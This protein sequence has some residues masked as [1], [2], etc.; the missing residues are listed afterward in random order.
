MFGLFLVVFFFWFVCFKIKVVSVLP[1]CEH[2]FL[3]QNSSLILCAC[4]ENKTLIIF[5]FFYFFKHEITALFFF[6]YIHLKIFE[7]LLSHFF[8]SYISSVKM[9]ALNSLEHCQSQLLHNIPMIIY[10][11]III[12][13]HSSLS[14]YASHLLYFLSL[15]IAKS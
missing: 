8:L 1:L 10:C 12:A 3:N 9:G 7:T 6:L 2:F 13:H 15:D 11:I 5:F 4:F 14:A